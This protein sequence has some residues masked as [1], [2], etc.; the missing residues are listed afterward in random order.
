MTDEKRDQI[1]LYMA[2]RLANI[3]AILRV[4]GRVGHESDQ[5][6]FLNEVQKAKTEHIPKP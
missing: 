2:E 1:L 3:E 6:K 4:I 5:D